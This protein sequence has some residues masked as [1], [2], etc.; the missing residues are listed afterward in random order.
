MKREITYCETNN[1]NT[2]K[3]ISWCK[4]FIKAYDQRK[5]MLLPD[6]AELIWRMIQ[7]DVFNLNVANC[8]ISFDK[9]TNDIGYKVFYRAMYNMCYI[10]HKNEERY[11]YYR[12]FEHIDC[13][14][15]IGEPIYEFLHRIEEML[16]DED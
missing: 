4:Y 1:L 13:I 12:N 16:P 6:I 2:L 8:E 11:I 5:L 3:F 10:V 7:R 14:S 9:I 15:L